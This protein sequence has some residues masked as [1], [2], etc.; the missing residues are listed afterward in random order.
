VSVFTAQQRRLLFVQNTL[1]AAV[2]NLVINGVIGWAI[3]RGLAAFPVWSIPGAAP[4]LAATAYGVSFGTAIAARF[5]VNFELRRGRI[6]AIAPLPPFSD[7]YRRLPQ[8][9]FARSI[10]FGV[11][12]LPVFAAPL[13]LVLLVVGAPAIERTTFIWLKAG[14]SA[15]QAAIVTPL[16]VLAVLF[17]LSQERAAAAKVS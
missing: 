5:G 8:N 11:V 7:W 17:D 6:S 10:W 12:S 14:F 3:T 15:V 13:L 4:D 16:I 1:G 9:T 2:V